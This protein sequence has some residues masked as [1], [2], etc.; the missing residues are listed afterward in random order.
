MTYHEKL[1]HDK[2][3]NTKDLT[4]NY[5]KFKK[6]EKEVQRVCV[7]R[8]NEAIFQRWA[9]SACQALSSR[10]GKRIALNEPARLA[11]EAAPN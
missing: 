8:R 2:E 9:A 11:P 3:V 4:D 6:L 10:G 7:K 1:K 5:I